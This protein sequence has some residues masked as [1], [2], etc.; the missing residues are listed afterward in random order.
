MQIEFSVEHPD[1]FADRHIG[2]DAAGTEA[3][4]AA[5][6]EADLASF[7]G[8]VV[9]EGIRIEPPLAELA[10]LTEQ[11]ALARL[12]DLAAKN[13]IYRSLIGQG[14]YNT[15]LPP[16]V[17]RNILENPGWYTAYTPYQA[18]ISQG[19][20][21][22]LLAF[23]TMIGELTG[24]ALANASLLD[25]ATAA[26]EAMTMAYNARGRAADRDTFWVEEN[27]HPQTIAV[28]RTRAAA[29]GINISVSGLAEFPA[30]K[31]FFGA[32]VQYPNTRGV[33]QDFSA[34]AERLHADQALLVVA[35][36]ILAL[37]VLTPP[38]K[39]GADVV[40]GSSQRFGMPLCFGGPHAA[41]FA[42]K[43]EFKRQMPGRL[44][45][46]SRDADGRR[47]L[48]LSLQTREQH[49]RRDKATSNICT[50]QVLPAVI[51]TAYAIYHGPEQ[52]RKIALRVS[53]LTQTLASY[54]RKHDYHIGGEAFFD[55]LTVT[56]PVE[57]QQMVLAKALAAGINLREYADGGVGVSLDELS[58]EQEVLQLIEIF[59]VTGRNV[60][61]E[62]GVGGG[63]YFD[64]ENSSLAGLRAEP[65]M[66]QE[67]FQR[68]HSETEMLRFLKRLENKDLSLTHSM[69]S[70]GSCTMKL[71]AT[72]E[73]LPV[74]WPLLANI[75][76]LA[77]ADQTA[78]Y[79]ELIAELESWLAALSGLAAVSLQPNSGANGEYAGLLAIRAWHES[80]GEGQR[81]I[82][83]IPNSAHGTNFASAAMAGLRVVVVNCDADGEVDLA[84][85]REKAD[86]N[87]EWLAC[88]MVTYPST[89]GVFEE[90]IVELCE[91][92][93]AAGGQVY[94]DGANM[95][96]QVGLTS[97]GA[98]GA[99]VC[100]LN[101]H[102]TFAIPLG[103]GGPGVGPVCVAEHLREFL[104]GN[105]ADGQ[106]SVSGA[107]F[108]SA[109]VLC[110]PWM[111]IAMMSGSGLA[112]ASAVAILNAN[113]L[114]QRLAG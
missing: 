13:Q 40:V 56:L 89:H 100:H 69:I 3:M 59:N 12:S 11:Q 102:K 78:G 64:I 67:I 33:I 68:Y 50:A 75:H 108:G 9:P 5:L 17:Q 76:P 112:R 18:E 41:F 22:L 25:E 27:C 82:C 98:I 8:K 73:M 63:R 57:L 10:P 43:D 32:L 21:E 105:P 45:G 14:Y 62:A 88:V 86:A 113:Y 97:P 79:A 71:N 110:I 24:L 94:M 104:P 52:L 72:A 103:G 92:V 93:H 107:R 35:A 84:D 47:A 85:L 42:T 83:L 90:R 109:G 111:Y 51:A 60:I 99:D 36:D 16:V 20:L 31:K 7:I 65:F 26:A 58:D 77:P 2:P 4:L 55:T 80:R 23:Q 66:R 39:F 70:L 46:V 37:T 61:E 74:T 96:A 28:V 87:H 95:N 114:A 6:G 29:L 91:I 48:R 53:A 38:A 19:R 49:I 81:R 101:L 44:I 106:R 34:L 54:L 1:I 30:E 15:I